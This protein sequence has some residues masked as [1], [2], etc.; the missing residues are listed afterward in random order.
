MAERVSTAV[1]EVFDHLTILSVSN[2]AAQQVWTG[3]IGDSATGYVLQADVDNTGSIF[4]GGS[5]V[6]A[7]LAPQLATNGVRLTAGTALSVSAKTLAT[8]YAK[9]TAAGQI[10]H[11][12]KN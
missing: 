10:L 11:I 8:L 9:A 4:V 5:T 3:P 1:G 6:T 2:V 12:L 7:N